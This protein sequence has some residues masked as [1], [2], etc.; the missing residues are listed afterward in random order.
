[1]D[2]ASDGSDQQQVYYVAPNDGLLPDGYRFNNLST[3]KD[4]R[5]R[6]AFDL[7][8]NLRYLPLHPYNAFSLLNYR[9]SC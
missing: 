6:K 7:S 5:M 3:P 1:M 4:W 2:A 8:E 9:N